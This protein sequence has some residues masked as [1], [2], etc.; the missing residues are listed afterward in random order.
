MD[1]RQ[2]LEAINNVLDP[3]ASNTGGLG[4]TQQH[5]SNGNMII[6]ISANNSR[7]LKG[8]YTH[9]EDDFNQKISKIKDS[10]LFDTS[11]SQGFINTD[12]M[13]LNNQSTQGAESLSQIRKNNH[14]PQAS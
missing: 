6:D 3:T 8:L 7:T 13:K 2:R 11:I 9:T 12:T 10:L 4:V 1:I 5:N 14:K